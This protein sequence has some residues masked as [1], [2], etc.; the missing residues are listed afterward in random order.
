MVINSPC[1]TDKK[2]LAIP[3]QTT[4]DKKCQTHRKIKRG[5]DT[6][7]PQSGGPPKKVGDEAVHKELVT[8]WK[9]LPL[10]LLSLKQSRT[11]VVV[12]GSMIRYQALKKKPVTVAQASGS[13]PSQEQST[14][15]SK[16]LSEEDLK[17]IL[18]IVP[19]EE[20]KAEAL[21]VKYPIVD[22]EVHTD[23]SRKY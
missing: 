11:V 2:E 18:E 23:G 21:Q 19:V 8:E 17:E 5:Q 15:E 4:T 12:L 9:G 1:L 7:V 22:W 10:L 3:W 20:T 14:E 16:E 13:E 6:K